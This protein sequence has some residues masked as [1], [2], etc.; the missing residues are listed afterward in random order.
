MAAIGVFAGLTTF[1][2]IGPGLFGFGA[3]VAIE[4]AHGLLRLRRAPAPQ[5]G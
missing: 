3:A 5:A 1:G 4:R 2:M